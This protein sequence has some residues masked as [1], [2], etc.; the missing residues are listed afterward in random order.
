VLS[1]GTR[2]GARFFLHSLWIYKVVFLPYL[3]GRTRGPRRSVVLIGGCWATVELIAAL[4]MRA[5]DVDV[6]VVCPMWVMIGL[7]P[8]CAVCV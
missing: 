5:A 3:R 8:L 1:F 4:P 7:S 2:H 6:F